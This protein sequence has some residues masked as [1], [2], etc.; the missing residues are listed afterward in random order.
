MSPVRWRCCLHHAL[1][2]YKF[3]APLCCRFPS[4]YP[5]SLNPEPYFLQ[6]RLPEPS[7]ILAL[8]LSLTPGVA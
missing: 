1:Y 5:K 7:V 2:P 8:L 4:V 3:P 6:S